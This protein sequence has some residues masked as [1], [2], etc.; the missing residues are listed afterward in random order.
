MGNKVVTVLV[1]SD[2]SIEN[3][4][5]CAAKHLRINVIKEE[6]KR[7]LSEASVLNS[8]ISQQESQT[9]FVPLTGR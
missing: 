5:N 7:R 1:R 3:L 9:A 8:R 4:G 2:I 6:R